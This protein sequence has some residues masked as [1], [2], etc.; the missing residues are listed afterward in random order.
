MLCSGMDRVGQRLKS[1]A[2]SAPQLGA[3]TGVPL[4]PPI[5]RRQDT[6]PG[7]SPWQRHHQ[8]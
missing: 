6:L 2:A 7:T 1:G 3:A 4:A 8:H 5:A